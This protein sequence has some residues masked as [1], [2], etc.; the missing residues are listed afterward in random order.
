MDL[1][2]RSFDLARPGVAPQLFFSKPSAF[3]ACRH[4]AVTCGYYSQIKLSG[5]LGARQLLHLLKSSPHELGVFAL[6]N[7]YYLSTVKNWS[8][9]T[10]CKDGH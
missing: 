6:R 4:A 5:T 3:S 10:E 9:I 2:A 1:P 7:C 8:F